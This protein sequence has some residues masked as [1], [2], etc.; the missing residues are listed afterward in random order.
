VDGAVSLA[1][2]R[3]TVS[4]PRPDIEPVVRTGLRAVAPALG[5]LGLDVAALVEDTGAVIFESD[6]AAAVADSDVVQENVPERLDLKQRVWAA[7]EAAAP[8]EAL[9]ASASSN[10]ATAIA[11]RMRR[12][13]RLVIG[14]PFNPPHL[15]P[16]VEV[17]PGARTDPAVAERAIPFYRAMGKRPQLVKKEIPGFVANPCRPRSSARRSISSARAWSPSRSSM[18]SSPARSGC[19]GPL[20]GR[21]KPST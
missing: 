21:F 3:V 11:E 13:E 17:V 18:T 8:T 14:H 4:D 12:P 1:G 2:L 10:F 15:V 5:E 16:L 19:A 9:L 6:V 7:V 20:R